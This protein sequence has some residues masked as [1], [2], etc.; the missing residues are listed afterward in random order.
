MMKMLVVRMTL[1]MLEK[2][3]KSPKLIPVTRMVTRSGKTFPQTVWMLPEDVKAGKTAGAQGS[4]FDDVGGNPPVM[5]G[6]LFDETPDEPKESKE[7]ITSKIDEIVARGKKRAE[8]HYKDHQFPS[9]DSARTD[10]DFL[11]KEEKQELHELKQKLPTYDEE[12]EAAKNRIKERVNARKNGDITLS[13]ESF[14]K[15]VMRDGKKIGRVTEA[16][17]NGKVVGYNVRNLEGALVGNAKTPEEALEKFKQGV[18][19]EEPT[20]ASTV[21]SENKPDENLPVGS[22]KTENGVTYRLNEN[23]RW[24]KVED[25][26]TDPKMKKIMEDWNRD[27]KDAPIKPSDIASDYGTSPAWIKKQFDSMVESGKLVKH[28][29]NGKSFYAIP[30]TKGAKTL[31]EL[32]AK[33]KAKQEEVDRIAEKLRQA[34]EKKKNGGTKESKE[35]DKPKTIIPVIP[36]SKKEEAPEEK[37]LDKVPTGEAGLEDMRKRVTVGETK[38]SKRGITYTFTAVMKDGVP[39]GK[40]S[41]VWVGSGGKQWFIAPV[42][43]KKRRSYFEPFE[44]LVPPCSTQEDAI[45]KMTIR[46]FN[47]EQEAKAREAESKERAK[48]IRDSKRQALISNAT[49][50]TRCEVEKAYYDGEEAKPEKYEKY[51]FSPSETEIELGGVKTTAKD[52]TGASQNRIELVNKK[53]ILSEE[54]PSYIP[55]ISDDWFSRMEYRLE[56]AKIGPD[57]Y[58]I[59]TNKVNGQRMGGIEVGASKTYAVVNLAVLV[60]T[61]DYYTKLAKAKLDKTISEAKTLAEDVANIARKIAEDESKSVPEIISSMDKFS[62]I[63]PGTSAKLAVM[64]GEIISLWKRNNELNAKRG[65]FTLEQQIESYTNRVEREARSKVVRMIGKDKA[66]RSHLTLLRE[67]VKNEPNEWKSF[68]EYINDLRQGGSDMELQM[69]ENGSSFTKGRETSYGRKGSVTY[70]RDSHGILVKRQNGDEITAFEVDEVKKAIE[71]VYSV[72]GDR[73]TMAKRNNLL[74]SHSGEKLMHAMK[75]AGV[76]FP[77]RKAIGVTWG[78]GQAGAGFTLAHEF[79]HFIDNEI[80]VQGKRFHHASDDPASLENEIAVTFRKNMKEKQ[81]SDYKNRTCEC[82]ARALEQYYAIEKGFGENYDDQDD[83]PV[84]TVYMEKVHPLVKRFFAEK[85]EMLKAIRVW[86]FV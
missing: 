15:D 49:P 3:R 33:R 56:G 80:G 24:E 40:L 43:E 41:E 39:V 68:R 44:E 30:G 53:T 83:H 16:R 48:K 77:G 21:S 26:I 72:F 86:R 65:G 47:E 10:M 14:P 6:D 12:A 4:L 55:A 45:E 64:A 19:K 2:A 52:F 5:Q 36:V 28:E 76:Y 75:F 46:L 81:D 27:A 37:P 32:T 25:D 50:A 69:E 63:G 62:N 38:L 17:L 60:A 51:E 73:T 8:D 13:G 82:F 78:S 35:D 61:Q 84:N 34:I 1:P 70:L 11:T 59:T 71:S 74:I 9:D 31:E 58:I 66:T 7:S 29:G 67:S 57:R 79:A 18:A 23:H 85:G 22:T 20:E 42:K 54:R